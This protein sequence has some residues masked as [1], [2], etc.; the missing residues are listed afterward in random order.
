M[1]AY[2]LTSTLEPK[3]YNTLSTVGT[4]DKA[5]RSD[6]RFENIL[7][8]AALLFRKHSVA[9]GIGLSLLHK[10]N[11]CPEGAWMIEYPY[12]IAGQAALITKLTTGVPGAFCTSFNERN[13][14]ERSLEWHDGECEGCLL[15]KAWRSASPVRPRRLEPNS[16]RSEFYQKD[17][18]PNCGESC[19]NALDWPFLT[20]S[21]LR[22]DQVPASSI[23]RSMHISRLKR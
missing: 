10:H 12:Q 2:T 6:G 14:N 4:A 7:S 17:R 23:S 9:E 16:A 3:R 11:E 8:Q 5:I 13:W 22:L 15:A 21:Q 20:Q 18:E 19:C 1:A